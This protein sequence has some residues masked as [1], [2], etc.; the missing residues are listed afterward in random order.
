MLCSTLYNV[1]FRFLSFQT[2]YEILSVSVK[3]IFW[4]SY[5]KF[6][7]SLAIWVNK[8]YETFSKI[9]LLSEHKSWTL[10]FMTV[11]SFIKRREIIKSLK[12]IVVLIE[13]ASDAVTVDRFQTDVLIII[14]LWDVLKQQA[15]IWTWRDICQR[16]FFADEFDKWLKIVDHV[17]CIWDSMSHSTHVLVSFVFNLTSEKYLT[18]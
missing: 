1:V 8:K 12:T 14:E 18:F 9:E 3:T 7:F 5:L 15:W 6:K 2:T 10:I 13:E 4:L 16:H 11:L 17:C